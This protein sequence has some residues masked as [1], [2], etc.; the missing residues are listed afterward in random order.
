MKTME[1]T[2]YMDVTAVAKLVRR[3]LK[4][5][6]PDVKFSVRSKSYSGGSSIRVRWTDGPSE[7]EVKAVVERFEGGYVDGMTD[8]KGGYVH[9]LNGERVDFLCDFI[10]TER[11]F[12]REAYSQALEHVWEMWGSGPIP[13]LSG[14]AA[15]YWDLDPD[16]YLENAEAA[17]HDLIYRELRERSFGEYPGA[18]AVTLK[19]RVIEKF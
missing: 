2:K 19:P 5:A 10:F 6:F 18:D 1:Q 11:K 9:E 13:K 17:L 3:S 16:P 4:E 7:P 12:S 14:G 8:Y 15:G